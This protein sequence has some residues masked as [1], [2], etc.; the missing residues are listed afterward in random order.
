MVAG[1]PKKMPNPLQ[2]RNPVAP[3]NIVPPGDPLAGLQSLVNNINTIQSNWSANKPASNPWQNL[4]NA[5]A[6]LQA[7]MPAQQ[8]PMSMGQMM[9][10]QASAIQAGNAAVDAGRAWKLDGGNGQM[11]TFLPR[12]PIEQVRGQFMQTHVEGARDK[13]LSRGHTTPQMGYIDDRGQ[14]TSTNRLGMLRRLAAADPNDEEVKI[15]LAGAEEVARQ[16]MEDRRARLPEFK[17]MARARNDAKRARAGR[18]ADAIRA[19]MGLS[20]VTKKE[21]PVNPITGGVLPGSQPRTIENQL[22]AE[23]RVAERASSPH[24]LGADTNR[25]FGDLNTR[26]RDQLQRDPNFTVSDDTLKAWQSHAKDLAQLSTPDNDL[27]RMPGN[28]RDPNHVFDMNMW[29]KLSTLPDNERERQRWLDEYKNPEARQSRTQ[30]AED[31]YWREAMPS[32]GM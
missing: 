26:F 22:A 23:T 6:S 13:A 9:S 15:A 28:D 20:R 18:Q 1:N 4:P 11:P 21:V 27:F 12:N 30:R 32:F 5:R 3:L 16:Q 14:M 7:P 19:R 25:G 10:Q 29:R 17:E 31:Q 24:F 8:R 2:Q